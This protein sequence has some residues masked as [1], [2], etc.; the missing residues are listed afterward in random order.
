MN[1]AWREK[2]QPMAW[3]GIRGQSG[4]GRLREPKQDTEEKGGAVWVKLMDLL[5]ERFRGLLR[6]E[7]GG[8]RYTHGMGVS[9]LKIQYLERG[10]I[11]H[12]EMD[13]F[14]QKKTTY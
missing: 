1:W 7:E 14:D 9:G 3:R 10:G 8:G 11:S 6:V 4:G 2:S 12:E 13:M 5:A